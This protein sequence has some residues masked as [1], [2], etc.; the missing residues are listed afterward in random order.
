MEKQQKGIFRLNYIK[1]LIL[2]LLL[3]IFIV[4]KFILKY[5]FNIPKAILQNSIFDVYYNNSH[6]HV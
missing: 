4:I 6:L 2:L 3:Y 1:T 5:Y